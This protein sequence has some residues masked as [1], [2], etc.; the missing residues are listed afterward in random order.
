M[1]LIEVNKR[2]FEFSIYFNNLAMT[3]KFVFK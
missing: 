2:K 3:N 1:P